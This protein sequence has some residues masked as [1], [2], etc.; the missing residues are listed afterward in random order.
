MEIHAQEAFIV[1]AS[2]RKACKRGISR[3][4]SC[5]A[6][7]GQGNHAISALDCLR[8]AVESRYRMIPIPP[9]PP[10]P[11]ERLQHGQISDWLRPP[12]HT[13]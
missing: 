2:A 10:A 8:E 4:T 3:Q 6:L 11:P 7:W 1:G 5:T 12:P 9:T 13:V